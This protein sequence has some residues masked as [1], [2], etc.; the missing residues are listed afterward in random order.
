MKR[1]FLN[2]AI[3]ATATL[4][5][6]T[7]TAET[8]AAPQISGRLYLSALYDNIDNKEHNTVTQTISNTKSDR[9]SL[10]SAGSRVRLTGEE[11]L[12]KDI[13]LEYR[14]E[15]SIFLDND[16]EGKNFSARNTYLGFKHDDY[17]TVRVGR[18]FT[19]DDDIDYVDQ[20][21]LYASGSGLPFSY[22]GQRTNNTI[23]YIS[24][25][26]NNGKTQIKLHYAMDENSDNNHG[27]KFTTFHDGVTKKQERDMIVGHILHEDTKYDA[28]ISYTH[29][30]EFSALRGMV[31]YKPNK[32]LTIGVIAQQTDYDSGNKEL[33]ALVSG[34]YSLDKTTNLYAQ[35]GHASN[36]EGHKDGEQ[37]K[38]SIGAIK[39]LKNDDGI[40]LRTFGSLSYLDQTSYSYKDR[41]DGNGNTVKDL[42][43]SEQNGFGL[44]VGLR[45]DF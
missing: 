6:A 17:G 40:R 9:L 10:N 35:V 5:I 28:G 33:G 14:L 15:Y 1:S 7:L 42:V 3:K 13:D 30:G 22:G 34:L 24:P 39:S 44:E 37:T 16:G 45:Y 18:I 23:Q 36:Y 8:F 20:S 19:P 12:T 26:F 2:T 29:A 27:G 41:Q 4:A 31:S 11:K 21:Y 25:K 38:A 32:K 43:R